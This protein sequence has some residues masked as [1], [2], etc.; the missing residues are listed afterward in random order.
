MIQ[1]K[2]LALKCLTE[3]GKGS[4]HSESYPFRAGFRS[5]IPQAMYSLR[6]GSLT[7]GSGWRKMLNISYRER[8]G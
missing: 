2:G 4:R 5:T 1:G 7:F 3:E 8:D 6:F